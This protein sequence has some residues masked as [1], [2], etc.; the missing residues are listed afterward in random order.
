[1]PGMLDE[2]LPVMMQRF[3]VD[4]Q[5]RRAEELTRFQWI[6]RWS[7][8]PP[9]STWDCGSL[10]HGRALPDEKARRVCAPRSSKLWDVGLL[11]RHGVQE[12]RT[13]PEEVERD[14]LGSPGFFPKECR[15]VQDRDVRSA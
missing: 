2:L 3:G 13:F 5:W 15:V 1:M 7:D 8:R 6:K 10:V 9:G 14:G 12:E 11:V 4:M